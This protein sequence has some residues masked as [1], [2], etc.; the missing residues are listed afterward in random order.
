[1][2]VRPLAR[3]A[4]LCVLGAAPA[5]LRSSEDA[6][7]RNKFGFGADLLRQGKLANATPEI[8]VQAEYGP[9]AQ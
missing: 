8:E 4:R 7:R 2:R 3:T 5:A 6:V 1:M 9:V